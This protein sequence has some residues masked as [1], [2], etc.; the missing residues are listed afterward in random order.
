MAKME[1][2]VKMESERLEREKLEI[3][4]EKYAGKQKVS[5]S[6][7]AYCKKQKIPGGLLINKKTSKKNVAKLMI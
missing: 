4:R 3:E 2:Q 7:C 5:T 6:S 1:E